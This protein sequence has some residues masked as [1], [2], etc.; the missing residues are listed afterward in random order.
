VDFADFMK[1]VKQLGV[2]W[3]AVNEP[4]PSAWR[5]AASPQNDEIISPIKKEEKNAIPAPHPALGR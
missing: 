2:F 3:A 4:P 5:E 1:A